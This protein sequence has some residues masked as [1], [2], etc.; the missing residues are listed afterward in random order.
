MQL[1]MM[2]TKMTSGEMRKPHSFPMFLKSFGRILQ[3]TLFQ[4]NLS[5]GL[6]DFADEVEIQ[7]LLGM[8]VP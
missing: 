8:G 7:R 4:D 6:R 1:M 5:L 2:V 3:S